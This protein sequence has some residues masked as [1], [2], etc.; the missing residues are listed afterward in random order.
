MYIKGTIKLPTMSLPAHNFSSSFSFSLFV[1]LN[2][3]AQYWYNLILQ[4]LLFQRYVLHYPPQTKQIPSTTVSDPS[5]CT[6]IYMTLAWVRG[7]T[8]GEVFGKNNM[9]LNKPNKYIWV[10]CCLCMLFTTNHHKM[11]NV[12]CKYAYS[13]WCQINRLKS[14]TACLSLFG[15]LV[16]ENEKLLCFQPAKKM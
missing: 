1:S 16:T 14:W 15:R 8:D 13:S 7:T 10:L 3:A 11:K 9:F 5:T 2:T 6:F 4:Y 12:S